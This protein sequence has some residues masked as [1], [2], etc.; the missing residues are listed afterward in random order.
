MQVFP[1][2]RRR[3]FVI[4]QKKILQF[5][6]IA[7]LVLSTGA[8]CATLDGWDRL[9]TPFF[10][11]LGRA[12][13][14]PHPVA[15]AL[16]QDGDGFIWV[17]TQGGL[18]KYDGYHFRTFHHRD[19]DPASLPSDF[20]TTL[21]ADSHGRLW[22][23]GPSG[24]ISR[25]DPV[26]EHFISYPSPAGQ[27]N[28]SGVFALISDGDGGV[29]AATGS[30]LEHIDGATGAIT[31][32]T[33]QNGRNGSLP[34]DKVRTLL[35]TRDGSLWVSTVGGV[36]RLRPGGDR[37]EPVPITTAEGAPETDLV[38]ALTQDS[39]DRIWFTTLHLNV[40]RMLPSTKGGRHPVGPAAPPPTEW[41]APQIL[42]PV[43]PPEATGALSMTMLEVRPGEIWLGTIA[44]GI[45]ILDAASGRP[46]R[47]PIVH[48]PLS[49]SGFNDD[50]ARAFLRDRSGML[51]VAG[52][53]GVSK[54]NLQSAVI[55]NI[56]PN[57][58]LPQTLSNPNVLSIGVAADGKIW[59]GMKPGANILDPL[60]GTTTPLPLAHTQPVGSILSL[61]GDRDGR[62]W[63]G[64][65]SGSGLFRDDPVTGQIVN[66]PLVSGSTSLQD[67]TWSGNA[68][69]VA[70]GPLVRFDPATGQSRLYRHQ[71][72][73]DSLIDDSVVLTRPAGE[74]A[75][76]IGTKRGLDY[77]DT[78]DETFHHYTN[79]A[80]DPQSLPAPLVSALLTDRRGRLWVGTFGGG[81]GVADLPSG[82]RAPDRLRFRR[83]STAN[84][85][86]NNNIGA[87]LEDENGRIWGSTADGV[88]VIDPD[89]LVVTT[90]SRGDGL[91][92]DA[93]WVNSAA[94]L[95]DGTLLFGGSGGLTVIHP[96]RFT[97]WTYHPPMVVTEWRINGHPQPL[98]QTAAPAGLTLDPR[99]RT[100]EVSFATLDYSD[101]QSLR[102]TYK[103]Q[104]FDEDWI[105]TDA[106][107]RTA[108]YTN[109][110]PG[111]YKLMLRGANRAGIWGDPLVIPITVQ[112][113]WWQSL[114]F[115]SGLL[116]AGLAAILGL[117]QA[118][119]A[120]LRHRRQVLEDLVA[121][122]TCELME[123]NRRLEELAS[124]DSL[125]GI[126]NRRYFIEL[127]ER[128]LERASR[129][130]APVSLAMID[131]DHFKLVNDTYG[132]LVGDEVLR[133]V[134]EIIGQSLRATDLFAR[135]G[136][137]EL[138]VLMPDTPEPSA[139]I[140]AERLREAIASGTRDSRSAIVP[141]T[142]SIGLATAGTPPE[143]LDLLLDRAD[144]A[145]Y[146]AKRGGRNRVVEATA[147]GGAES[148]RS[149]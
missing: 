99:Q 19:D 119:T 40:G 111:S 75:L 41:D 86:P 114:W 125:T 105:S 52:S 147:M 146:A 77:F 56:L 24:G 123:A 95:A 29:W 60:R 129:T 63:M 109:L 112:A 122:Q 50:G 71:D 7:F 66:V 67:L 48:N 101:P 5:L 15:M 128:D 110:P 46:S 69:W 104:G 72:G 143:P 118:R 78:A 28:R 142:V 103:L 68:L 107:R 61:H 18:S 36:V 62:M 34:D 97:P 47:P 94:K 149:A 64:S 117:V 20:I 59:L 106:S 84:G 55:H 38:T 25:F 102:Y 51:W 141:V 115:R 53:I 81:I 22:I 96:D 100:L 27:P 16:A 140:V 42:G 145:L 57:P 120:Y 39:Q 2:R 73:Q 79:S 89:T 144:Q 49:T 91:A 127:A 135:V 23:G 8:H 9:S 76:W 93:Y 113:A 65:S 26:T 131:L 87:L 58:T 88:V 126:Y 44:N 32:Y 31:R 124:R 90:L 132:H 43:A 83:L 134:V 14:L 3:H 30:G 10:T 130:G 35:R 116:L 148:S 74:H 137:E 12:E 54:T 45:I 133:L 80:A 4:Y 1:S 6:S 37:F 121:Q 33:H 70:A 11:N 139:L 138:V 136:G 92:I 82:G 108:T 85:M 17:G 21:A 13:G 98:G